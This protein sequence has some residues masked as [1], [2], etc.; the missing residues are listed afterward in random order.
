MKSSDPTNLAFGVE[1]I[2]IQTALN[3]YPR[4][5]LAQIFQFRAIQI[6][7]LGWRKGIY[8]T[9][10]PNSPIDFE[11]DLQDKP[12]T[13][14]FSKSDSSGNIVGVIR[15]SPSVDTNGESISILGTTLSQLVKEPLPI[16]K[17]I[18]EA[19]RLVLD[20]EILHTPELRKPVVDELLGATVL[21][22]MENGIDEFF[23]FMVEDVWES[24]YQRLGFELI[25][26]GEKTLIEDGKNQFPVIA[27]RIRFDREILVKINVDSTILNY[28]KSF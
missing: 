5:L 19:S 2:S 28:G 12:G 14:Y 27:K 17:N 25:N 26:L 21:F 16:G 9:S 6:Q 22:A 18:Y 8:Y 7:K 15:L 24:T 13:V 4:N 23:G 11:S 10:L 20:S 1:I 3:F